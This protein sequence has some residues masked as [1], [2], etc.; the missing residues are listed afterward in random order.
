MSTPKEG[1]IIMGVADLYAAHS[2]I[3]FIME[4]LQKAL[5]Q[6]P[7]RFLKGLVILLHFTTLKQLPSWT[8]PTSTNLASTK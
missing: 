8:Q 7:R 3:R 2:S 4:T 6:M 1:K 5:Y